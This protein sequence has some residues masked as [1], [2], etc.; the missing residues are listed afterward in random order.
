MGGTST[1]NTPERLAKRLWEAI[2]GQPEVEE[3]LLEHGG[4]QL[5]MLHKEPLRKQMEEELEALVHG[6]LG[7]FDSQEP[8][9]KLRL[10]TF[11]ADVKDISP[12]L[13]ELP[14]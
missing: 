8:V 11:I 4:L 3:Q 6:K 14:W 13:W 7:K 1:S 9:E 12:T 10:H 2:L 5:G